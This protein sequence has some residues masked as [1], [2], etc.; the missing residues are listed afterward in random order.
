MARGRPLVRLI[1]L[2]LTLGGRPG[3]TVAEL[4]ARLDCVERTVWRDLQVLEASGVP[5]TNEREGRHTRW[6]IL[7]GHGR[8]LGIPFTHDE[9]LAL[10]FGRHLLRPL[11]GTV[12]QEAL[13]SALDKIQA[14]VS[15]AAQQF[16]QQLDQG[17]SAR[18]P[19]FKDYSRF[20]EA[21]EVL[22][23]AIDR[24]RTVEMEYH[25]FGRDD[26][27]VRRV[28]PYHL[29][30]QFGGLYLAARC[31]TR[32]EVLTFAI[33]RIRRISPRRETFARAPDFDLERYLAGSFGLYRGKPARVRLRFSRAVARYVAERQWHPTQRLDS[34]LTGEL[35]MT[36]QVAPEIDLKR[37]ILSYGKDVEV[38]EPG[39]L[40]AE[41]QAEWLAALRGA[42]GRREPVTLG[43]PPPAQVRGRHARIP[44]SGEEPGPSVRRAATTRKA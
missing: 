41:I 30:Y 19:G 23:E 32:Q 9:L 6:F 22:R 33:E 24:R 5:L 17:I 7:D 14:G 29:W 21:I 39:K 43:P 16:L 34:L 40:R 38:L 8:S 10:H 3:R 31:H 26:V 25:S 42:G 37:W 36:L 4:A 11:E 1:K 15:P 27:T 13:R 44:A 2:M 35:E 18:T 28:D 12:F 20:R